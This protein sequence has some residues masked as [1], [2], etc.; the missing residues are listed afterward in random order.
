MEVWEEVPPPPPPPAAN[1]SANG[2][3]GAEGAAGA[4][5]GAAG[6]DEKDEDK[7][8]EK[9]ADKKAD[10]KKDEKKGG[11]K[12]DEKKGGKAAEAGAAP[13]AEEGPKLRK[14]TVKVPL[15]VTGGLLAPGMNDTEMAVGAWLGRVCEGRFVQGRHEGV[16]YIAGA[17]ERPC[18]MAA[19]QR[20][21][22]STRSP[23][24]SPLPLPL[25][26]PAQASRRVMR[27]LRAHDAAK[28]ETAK[29]RNDLEAYAIATRDQV[30]AGAGARC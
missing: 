15:N 21:C 22:P 17:G 7:K 23:P 30:G 9:K 6:K 27:R 28:R 16:C 24:A 1:A 20:A 26:L 3:E 14:R 18:A 12:K 29:A 11:K 2:T 10:K 4:E 25:A 5:D 13:E 19:R 8:A